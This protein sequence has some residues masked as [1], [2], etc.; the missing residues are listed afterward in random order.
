VEALGVKTGGKYL[1]A[2]LGHGGH[3][4]ELLKRSAPDGQVWAID[5]DPHALEAAKSRLAPFGGRLIAAHG[6]YADVGRLFPGLRPGGL[7]GALADLGISTRQVLDPGRG[8]SFMREGPLDM[9]MDPTQGET[10]AEFLERVPPEELAERLAESGEGRFARKLAERLAGRKW[11]TTK[12]LADEV[13]RSIPRRGKSHP[14]TRVFLALR[15]AVNRELEGVEAF[16]A[17]VPECLKAG[18]RLAVI[19]F[20][21]SEDRIVK[22]FYKARPELD[23]KAVSKSPAIPSWEERKANPRSRSAKLRVFE[24]QI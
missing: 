11:P 9:R 24:K 1:D 20:H 6:H 8:F 17:A 15:L 5:R 14:A 12:A 16:L 4:A 22:R 13:A 19:T 3:A 23:M 18:G 2:T 10:A 21:S 7:D